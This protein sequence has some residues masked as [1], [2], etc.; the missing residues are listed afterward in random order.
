MQ[1]WSGFASC[2]LLAHGNVTAAGT[3]V[4]GLATNRVAAGTDQAPK[5]A[6]ASKAKGAGASLPIQRAVGMDMRAASG[7][8]GAS[9]PLGGIGVASR[10]A[11]AT[12]QAQ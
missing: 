6:A 10:P 4:A 3:S 2:A 11:R 7:A 9:R 1:F 8:A 12:K 5:V